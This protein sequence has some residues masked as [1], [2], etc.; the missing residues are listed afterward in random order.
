MNYLP[1]LLISIA[2]L[3][4]LAMSESGASVFWQTRDM[5][6]CGGDLRN[7][8][9]TIFDG[10]K[11]IV[12]IP[13]D[14]QVHTLMHGLRFA[15]YEHDDFVLELGEVSPGIRW[16]MGGIVLDNGRE[17]RELIK[18]E[19][20]GTYR[21]PLKKL[22]V[23][24]L[25]PIDVELHV[26]SDKAGK[27]EVLRWAVESD[28]PQRFDK[29]HTEADKILKGATPLERGHIPHF[30]PFIGG[31]VC[32]CNTTH[33]EYYNYWLE[34]EG[35]N[36]WSLGN[37]PKM[38]KLYGKPIRDFI[39]K[40]CKAGA[41]VRRVNDQPLQA[42]VFLT[43][44]KYSIDTG[45]IVATGDLAKNPAIDVR[46]AVYETHGLLVSLDGFFL[47]Y[48]AAD[49]SSRRVDFA[50]PSAYDIKYNAPKK[51]AAQLV[52]EAKDG[53]ISGKFVITIFHDRLTLNAT[54]TN[55]S[56]QAIDDVTAGFEIR[57]CR[58]YWKNP[59]NS[60]K[61]LGN[62][63]LL[64][65]EQ[66]MLEECNIVR[67]AGPAA[68]SVETHESKG[69]ISGATVSARLSAKLAAGDKKSLKMADINAGATSYS[70]NIEI[71]KNVDF[72]EAD[73]SMSYVPT[74]A[75]LGLATYSY[76]FPEDKE[77]RGV[78]DL[79]MDNFFKARTRLNGRDLGYFLWVLDL[80]GRN[81][82]AD[83]VADM[84]EKQADGLDEARALNGA[85]MAIGLRRHGRWEAADKLTLK[86][87]EVWDFGVVPAAEF[88]GSGALQSPSCIE[89][90]YRQL[91]FNLSTMYW[92]APD[93]ITTHTSRDVEE[94]PAETQ[95]Y[96]LVALDIISRH[97]GGITPI[98]IDR[99]IKT[100]I[101]KMG[102]DEKTAEW[103]ISMI[104]SKDVDIFT[105]FRKPT[106]VLWN[107]QPLDQSKWNY[108]QDTGVIYVTGLSGEGELLLT[109]DGPAPKDDPKWKPIDY[110]GLE[111]RKLINRR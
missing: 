3:F 27:M 55:Q 61:R 66:P 31:F 22:G 98:R 111:K 82:E 90:A 68:K 15:D 94:G 85:G 56:G 13:G 80:M 58:K 64:Y 40:Y 2:A 108:K 59:L 104:R 26:T 95:A 24:N 62:V 69:T 17:W 19:G 29:Q 67:I 89:K 76:R 75:L 23:K 99:P 91:S 42:N 96:T 9:N 53:D 10:V 92:D 12:S 106:R 32:A 70:E 1:M 45:L 65:S 7:D 46:H 48:K 109:V 49:G 11:S 72:P 103:T 52:I 30:N 102:W 100:E 34:D 81:K 88:L 28:H 54:A 47:S 79:M 110:L 8:G 105:H 74:Y 101:T 43:S 5:I 14:G 84:L 4:A 50:T 37:Y 21:V 33:Q 57:N 107:G 93:K 71:Y 73:I 36:L 39:V 38:M 51:D 6:H 83:E 78:V 16:E 25:S 97:F 20:G 63:T 86:I 41:P 60:I 87:K 35:E 77:A 44:G 18:G